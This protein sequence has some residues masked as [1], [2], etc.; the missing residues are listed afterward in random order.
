[1]KSGPVPHPSRPL[2]FKAT[3]F[4]MWLR[5]RAPR[6]HFEYGLLREQPLALSID[7]AYI[8]AK[9]KQKSIRRHRP[10]ERSKASSGR[11]TASPDSSSRAGGRLRAA[12]RARGHPLPEVDRD[13]VGGG[14]R[15]QRGRGCQRPAHRHRRRPR[16]FGLTLEEFASLT[17]LE[18]L[19][20]VSG[21]ATSMPRSRRRPRGA[22]ATRPSPVP[23][24]SANVDTANVVSFVVVFTRFQV[25]TTSPSKTI[26]GR[27][28]PLL[29]GTIVVRVR[30]QS[31]LRSG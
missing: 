7:V 29:P 17:W 16:R 13:T 27:K 25:P 23:L 21:G 19:T 5:R 8:D 1:M 26:V 20:R 6:P 4:P 22:S 2:D 18:H 9:G 14:C 11:C 12:R 30:R 3:N 31:A 28:R 10:L 24:S 15:G